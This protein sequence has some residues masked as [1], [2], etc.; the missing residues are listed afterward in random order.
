M[1]GSIDDEGSI[2][3]DLDESQPTY[4]ELVEI[5]TNGRGAMPSFGG[6]ISEQDIRDVSAYVA[7][8]AGT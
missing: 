8:V 4:E 6:D 5:V 7:E 3:P 2:G 1:I